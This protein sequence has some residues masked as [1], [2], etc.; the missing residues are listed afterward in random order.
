MADKTATF[1]VA[2]SY[3]NPG[4]A[5][6]AAPPQV[7]SVPYQAMTYG[8]LDIPDATAASTEFPVSLAGIG[9]AATGIMLKNESG[10]ELD[11]EFNGGTEKPFSIPDDGLVM[12]AFPAAPA[13]TP[14]TALTV[15]T[16]AEQTG[17]GLVKYWAF[18]DPTGV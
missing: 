13:E 18:G 1:S 4:G 11:V 17:E 6:A 7:A 3:Q 16:S 12:L 10:Q 9:T 8:E 5:I 15:T 2:L 14:I